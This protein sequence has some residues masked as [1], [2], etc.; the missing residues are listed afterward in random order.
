VTKIT[1]SLPNLINLGTELV[2]KLLDVIMANVPVLIQGAVAIVTT[3][4]LGVAE[5]ADTLISGILDL[6]FVLLDTIVEQLPLLLE[7]GLQLLLALT[8]GIVNNIDKIIAGILNVLLK[9]IDFI[10]QNLP[11][12]IDMGIKII[13][14][15]AQGLAKAIPQLVAAIPVIVKAIFKAFGDVDWG[16]IGKSIIEGLVAGL[17]ALKNLVVDTLKNIAKGAVDAFKSF[18]GINSPST[19]FMNFGENIDKGLAIGLDNGLDKVE[20]AM[21]NLI[22][23]TTFVPSNLDYGFNGLSAMNS[24]NLTNV[25]NSS[26]VVNLTLRIEHFENNRKEDVEEIM[27]EMDFIA[28]KELLGN[29]GV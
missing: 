26:K 27:R 5:N 10:A 25:N 17:K 11:M 9:L 20:D 3:L 18:F 12:I 19:L 13:I 24:G 8:Q 14:A 21:D 15:L 23:T 1:E 7:C 29:G 6:I 4:A 22:D 28:K 16:A 2:M